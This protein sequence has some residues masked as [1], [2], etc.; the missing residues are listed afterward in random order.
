M[1]HMVL[2]LEVA[3]KQSSSAACLI[4]CTQ[5]PAVTPQITSDAMVRDISACGPCGTLATRKVRLITW[6]GTV[7]MEGAADAPPTKV[8][9]TVCCP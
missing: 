9:A 3:W 1:T 6:R 8:A 7:D 5:V 4:S 2:E